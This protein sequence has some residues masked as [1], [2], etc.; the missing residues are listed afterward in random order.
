MELQDSTIEEAR[1][2]MHG[3]ILRCP[4]GGNPED[5]PLHEVRKWPVEERIAWLV[6]RTDQEVVELYNY[7]INCLEQKMSETADST[8]E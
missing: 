1:M 5:C 2:G 3:R 4:L 7:H 8:T 6:S